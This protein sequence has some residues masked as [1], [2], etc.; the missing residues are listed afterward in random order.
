METTEDKWRRERRELYAKLERSAESGLNRD[1]VLASRDLFAFDESGRAVPKQFAFQHEGDA[2]T[3]VCAEIPR[4]AALQWGGITRQV[5]N[6]LRGKTRESCGGGA[7]DLKDV[8]VSDQDIMH[9]TLF[10]TSHPDDLA[11]RKE[12]E[13]KSERIDREVTLLRELAMPFDPVRMTPVKVVLAASGAILL[14]LQCIQAD[15]DSNDEQNRAFAGQRPLNAGRHA[16]FSVDLLRQEARETFPF[17]SGKSPTA[18]IHTTLARVLSP[19][20]FDEAALNRVREVCH[21]ISVQLASA[22][23]N[24]ANS[25]VVSKLWY[26]DETH[27]IRPTGRTTTISLGAA[28]TTEATCTLPATM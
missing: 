24:N 20:A 9:V 27:F 19:D 6:A 17:V 4:S 25:F 2:V 3:V 23:P 21:H 16:E 10:Y 12:N 15:D 11:P 5:L 26:V 13:S 14:L 28:G 18:I 22:G 1:A 7:T 8:Y